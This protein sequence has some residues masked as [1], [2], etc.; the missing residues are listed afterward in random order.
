MARRP[1]SGSSQKDA[2]PDEIR[3]GIARLETRTKELEG[4]DRLD[5]KPYPVS[6]MPTV[7][8]GRSIC[9]GR[10]VDGRAAV[11][12][13]SLSPPI[14]PECASLAYPFGRM[15]E[16]ARVHSSRGS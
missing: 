14:E 1:P 16:T 15:H 6:V 2:P 5:L 13:D 3:N 9:E 12:V 10:N 8:T 4:F 11:I 7:L